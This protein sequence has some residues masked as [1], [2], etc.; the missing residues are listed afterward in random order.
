MMVALTDISNGDSDL[1]EADIEKFTIHAPAVIPEL[2]QVLNA[3]RVQRRGDP[4]PSPSGL[5]EAGRNGPCSCGS[6]K[7]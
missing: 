6:G 1:F 3:R 5:A 4:A 7:K 2:V